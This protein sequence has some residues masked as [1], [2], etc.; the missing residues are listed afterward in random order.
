MRYRSLDRIPMGRKWLAAAHCHCQRQ[1]HYSK[2]RFIEPVSRDMRRRDQTH[3]QGIDNN[4]EKLLRAEGG[5]ARAKR[6]RCFSMRGILG[7]S[8]ANSETQKCLVRPG[9][10]PQ[11]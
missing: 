10:K 5:G 9:G 6:V 11:V 1:L 3:H 4:I 7:R 8:W 2:T